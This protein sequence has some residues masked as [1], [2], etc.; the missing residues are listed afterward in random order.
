MSSD[1]DSVTH[2]DS[3]GK[4][5]VKVSWTAPSDFTGNV[6]VVGTVVQDFSTYW[7][8]D[9]S[10]TISVKL[11]VVSTGTQPNPSHEGSD[12]EPEPE[13]ETERRPPKPAPEPKHP[14]FNDCFK[15]KG[16]FGLPSNCESSG[17]CDIAV[18]WRFKEGTTEIELFSVDG[19][20]QYVAVGFSGDD[21][22]GDDLVMS[23]SV[24]QGAPTV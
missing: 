16:C 7:V 22:M 4:E 9:T 14:V 24:L 11:P 20:G 3:S 17:S 23:C 2:S 1:Q 8:A 21:K 18:T 12:S 5:T 13:S 15:N 19:A 6:E 10:D